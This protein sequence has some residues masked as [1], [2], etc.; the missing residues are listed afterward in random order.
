MLSKSNSTLDNNIQIIAYINI[1]G[2][3]S[4]YADLD[5]SKMQMFD[6]LPWVFLFK[7]KRK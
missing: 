7:N 4:S 5:I 6:P 3:Q 2:S 1:F